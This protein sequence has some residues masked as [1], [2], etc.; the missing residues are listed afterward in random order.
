MTPE[1]KH[2]ALLIE[3]LIDATHDVDSPLFMSPE[4]EAAALILLMRQVE[5]R[6]TEGECTVVKLMAL[7]QQALR[8]AA[9]ACAQF[10]AGGAHNGIR[11]NVG[12]APGVN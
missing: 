9:V 11:L 7:C 2:Q 12:R 5:A 3:A 1:I 8:C 6:V 4:K 10:D